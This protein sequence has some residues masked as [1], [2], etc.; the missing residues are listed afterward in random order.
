MWLFLALTA[1]VPVVDTMFSVTQLVIK[2]TGGERHHYMTGE[3]RSDLIVWNI[4]EIDPIRLIIFLFSVRRMEKVIP[5]PDK[6]RPGYDIKLN[7]T[8]RIQFWRFGKCEIPLHCYYSQAHSESE[9][10]FL[11]R[12]HLKVKSIC[13]KIIRIQMDFLKKNLKNVNINVKWTPFSDLLA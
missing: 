13:L 11:L 4:G 2:F 12:S 6:W 9:M 7:L 5:T 8:V 1:R 3:R 10:Q